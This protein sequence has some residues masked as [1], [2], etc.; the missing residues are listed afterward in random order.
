M[1]IIILK[2]K[3]VF[4]TFGELKESTKMDIIRNYTSEVEAIEKRFENVSNDTREKEILKEDT[5]GVLARLK[6]SQDTEAYFDL[7]DDF[8]ELI[9]RLITIIGKLL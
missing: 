9:S 6:K 4:F 5:H 8:E 7:N 1:L 2:N 3:N